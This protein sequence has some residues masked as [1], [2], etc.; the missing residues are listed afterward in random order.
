MSKENSKTLKGYLNNRL[1]SYEKVLTKTKDKN[2][3][4]LSGYFGRLED[5]Q[6]EY[7]VKNLDNYHLDKNHDHT[8]LRYAAAN[9]F[10]ELVAANILSAVA[11]GISPLTSLVLDAQ[12]GIKL[13]TLLYDNFETLLEFETKLKSQILF[14]NNVFFI[15]NNQIDRLKYNAGLNKF[16]AANASEDMKNQ[17]ND[18]VSIISGKE[19]LLAAS[20]F[21]GEYDYNKGNIGIVSQE[22]SDLRCVK[23]DHGWAFT[24]NFDN[25]NSMLKNFAQSCSKGHY[26]GLQ[27]SVKVNFKLFKEALEQVLKI[28]DDELNNLIDGTI[29]LLKN[30]LKENSKIYFS[31]FYFIFSNSY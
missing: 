17:Y 14:D 28:S 1:P 31:S 12:G 21:V 30:S 15:D 13:K 18:K 24:C 10:N 25:S 5:S 2:E 26:F 19:K 22:N 3:G 20:L 6:N 7:I 29:S 23:I 11:P 9:I 4:I 16:W 8:P 27:D